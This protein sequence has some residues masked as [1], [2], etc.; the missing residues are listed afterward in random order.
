MPIN[1]EAFKKICANRFNAFM[2]TT[3]IPKNMEDDDDRATIIDNVT[4]YI[5][6]RKSKKPEKNIFHFRKALAPR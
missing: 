6:P 4:P 3:D 2:I 5:A 1:K